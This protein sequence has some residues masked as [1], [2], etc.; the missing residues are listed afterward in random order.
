MMKKQKITISDWVGVDKIREDFKKNYTDYTKY[1]IMID[2]D[3]DLEN[4]KKE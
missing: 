2:V 1:P 4:T 3:W